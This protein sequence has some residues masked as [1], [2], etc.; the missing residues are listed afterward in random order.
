M[1]PPLDTTQ[2]K[3]VI[4]MALV[5]PTYTTT[6]L[7]LPERGRFTIIVINYQKIDLLNKLQIVIQ[8]DLYMTLHVN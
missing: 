7:F 5:N 8:N 3:C 6:F 1:K 4:C 2:Y